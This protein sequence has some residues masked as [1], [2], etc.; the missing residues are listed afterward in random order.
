MLVEVANRNN[1]S[2]EAKRRKKRGEER[3]NGT[4]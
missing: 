3:E 2:Q 1:A 4:I